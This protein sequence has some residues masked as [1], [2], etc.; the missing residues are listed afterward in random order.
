MAKIHSIPR[1]A[2][3]DKLAILRGIPPAEE[4]ISPFPPIRF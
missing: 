2:V 3:A 1:I 4:F